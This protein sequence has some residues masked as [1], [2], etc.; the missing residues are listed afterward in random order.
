M[1]TLTPTQYSEILTALSRDPR[2]FGVP[3]KPCGLL[4][5][6]NSNR[7]PDQHVKTLEWSTLA[8][9]PPF[10]TISAMVL[11]R[12]VAYG[13][14][15]TNQQYDAIQIEKPEDIDQ[16]LEIFGAKRSQP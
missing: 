8:P 16:A 13:R 5:M 1:K 6:A 12:V 15:E 14:S 10:V 2:F 3:M 11:G 4:D 7:V 9:S